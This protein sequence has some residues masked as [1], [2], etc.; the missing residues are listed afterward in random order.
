MA[1][2]WKCASPKSRSMSLT[3]P[4][5]RALNRTP[6]SPRRPV[7]VVML[8]T[9]LPARAPHTGAQSD[10]PHSGLVPDGAHAQRHDLTA[11]ASGRYLNRVPAVIAGEHADVQLRD[12]DG[13]DRQRLPPV[14][15]DSATNH[16]VLRQRRTRES[17]QSAGD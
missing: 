17:E 12:L 11:D 5:L 16:G 15:D 6:S 2:A 9:P 7:F 4:S 3:P 13:R 8:M 14:V 10:L 1:S